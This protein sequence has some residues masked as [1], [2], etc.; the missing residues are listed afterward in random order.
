MPHVICS[1]HLLQIPR[2]NMLRG[3]E[4]CTYTQ[5]SNRDLTDKSNG[6]RN[7][8]EN[9]SGKESKGDINIFVVVIGNFCYHGDR[10]SKWNSVA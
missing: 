6:N 3:L 10:G 1:S 8:I 5:Y 7:R 4:K 9:E 2:I